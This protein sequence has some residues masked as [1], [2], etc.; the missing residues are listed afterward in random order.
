[1]L[2][3]G[4]TR[5]LTVFMAST[6]LA[7]AALAQEGEPTEPPAPRQ[8]VAHCLDR[9]A[10]ITRTTVEEIHARTENGVEN[11]A[12][13]AQDDAGPRR[14]VFAGDIAKSACTLAAARGQQALGDTRERCLEAL[15]TLGAPPEAFEVV[16][17]ARRRTAVA[18]GEALTA[19]KRR[20]NHTVARAIN[21]GD[22][23]P[24][25]VEAPE[26]PA[27]ELTD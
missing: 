9:M 5:V 22:G 19:C 23:A 26:T 17:E 27:V 10:E 8:I 20:V 18:I 12:G 1:M 4:A 14:I 2:I 6:C 11:I 7:G 21:A 13:L 24:A 3:R 16:I 15:D 25:P